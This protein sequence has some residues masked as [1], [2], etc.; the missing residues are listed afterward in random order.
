MVLSIKGGLRNFAPDGSPEYVRKSVEN[1]LRMLGPVG[2]IDIF[3]CARRDPKVPLETTLNTLAQLVN[4]GKIGGVGLSEVSAA[5]IRQAAQVTKIVAVEIELSLWCTEPL[6]NGIAAACKELDIPIVAYS[7]VG[8]GFL[9]GQLKRPEDIPEDDMR[10]T[11]PQFQAE[12]WD[13]N[14]K[15]VQELEKVATEKKCTP[16]QLAIGWLLTLSKRADM[17]TIVPIP[18]TRGVGRIEENAREVLLSEEEMKK[19]ERILATGKVAGE[20]YSTRGMEHVNG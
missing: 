10:R 2:K 12:N 13:T 19:I 3:E 11:F 7:P 6:T 20:R 17:P 4:E 15:L 8:R 18:G 14:M 9:T 1:C 16:A 5:T